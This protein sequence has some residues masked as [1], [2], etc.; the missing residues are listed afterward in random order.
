MSVS[1]DEAILRPDGWCKCK[2]TQCYLYHKALIHIYASRLMHKIAYFLHY[3]SGP[4]ES[5]N[6]KSCGQAY[7]N[8]EFQ[9]V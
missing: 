5:K 6:S 3:T 1:P 2:K 8:S 4:W 7:E 9:T